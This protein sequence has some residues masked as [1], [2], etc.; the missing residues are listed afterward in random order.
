MAGCA[1]MHLSQASCPS[2]VSSILVGRPS[3][4]TSPS[5]MPTSGAASAFKKKLGPSFW[6]NAQP[7]AD[8]APS[9]YFTGRLVAGAF[10][11]AGSSICG[12]ASVAAEALTALQTRSE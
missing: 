12:K 7:P 4:A 9:A 5:N 10:S 1:G 6:M 2:V 8:R 3:E 11:C